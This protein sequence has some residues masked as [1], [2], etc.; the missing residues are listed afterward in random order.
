MNLSLIAIG[1]GLIFSLAGYAF[2][3]KGFFH[4]FRLL[5]QREEIQAAKDKV[6]GTVLETSFDQKITTS[7]KDA[8]ISMIVATVILYFC[9]VGAMLYVYSEGNTTTNAICA[10]RTDLESRTKQGKEYVKDHPHGIAG[11]SASS[12]KESIHNQERSIKALGNLSC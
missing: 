8:V 10:L 3:A 6:S 11:I 4:T 5:G 7:L 12:I 2:A 1:I 9:V